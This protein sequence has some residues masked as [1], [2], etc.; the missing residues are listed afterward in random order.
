MED[1][2]PLRGLFDSHAHYDDEAFDAD[3]AS[4]L[5]ERLPA[6]GVEFVLNAA[7]DAASIQT[8]R[9]LCARY[10]GFYCAAGYHPHTAKEALPGYLSQLREALKDPKVV[11]IGE[12]GLDYH[13]DLSERSVQQRIFRE[14]LQL[15]AETGYPVI[16][17]MRE[18]TADTLALLREYRPQG[19][20]HC[21]SGSAET[22]REILDLGLYLGFTG[23][24]T[25]VNAKKARGAAAC[26]PPDRL[27][28][29]TDCP[30]MT[31]VPFRGKRN[32]STLLHLTARTIAALKGIEPQALAEITAE[33]A[34]R[35]Y[36]IPG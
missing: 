5:G 12:I 34:R 9:E 18:A 26:V 29:E 7:T 4:L 23:L 32:D 11:A 21:F 3:R 36:R 17:H 24:V 19:V 15:A 20:V 6:A 30:Y 10:P 13:Y 35:L 2:Q 25:F 14:Q 27:L 33:N 16:I 8:G 28:I 22:A 1:L 31:P